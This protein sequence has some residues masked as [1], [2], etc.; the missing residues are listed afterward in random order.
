MSRAHS[1]ED[2][3]EEQSAIQVRDFLIEDWKI[4]TIRSE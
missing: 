1:F 4:S 2:V 3:R